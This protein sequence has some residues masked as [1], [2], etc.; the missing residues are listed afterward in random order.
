MG[1]SFWVFSS[2]QLNVAVEDSTALRIIRR[3]MYRYVV[4]LVQATSAFVDTINFE[5]RCVIAQLLVSTVRGV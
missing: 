5:D 1:G 3:A 2:R 4:G